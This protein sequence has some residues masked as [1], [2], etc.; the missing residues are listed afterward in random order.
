MQRNKLMCFLKYTLTGTVFLCTLLPMIKAQAT[1]EV[2]TLEKFLSVVKQNHPVAR[3]T[4]LFMDMASAG[5]VEAG[6]AFDP[7]FSLTS[8]QKTFDGKKYYTQNNA[9]LTIPTWYGVSLYGGVQN[10]LGTFLDAEKSP[11]LYT[12]AGVNVSVLKNLILDK[13]RASLQQAKLMQAQTRFENANT[14]NDLI[15]QANLSYFN[16]LKDFLVLQLI[17]QAVQINID[18]F[19]FVKASFL[20]GDKAGIDTIEAKTQLLTFLQQREE[21]FLAY[22]ASRLEL[23]TYLWTENEAPL[24][25][26][27]DVIPDTT[28]IDMVLNEINESDKDDWVRARLDEHPKLA[29][30]DLKLQNL[31]IERKLKFQ[32]FLPKLDLKYDFMRKGDQFPIENIGASFFEDNYKFG[33]SFSMPIFNRSAMGQYQA[34]KAKIQITS[35]D[36]YYTRLQIE[37]KIRFQLIEVENVKNQVNIYAEASE[38]YRQLYEAE[39]FKFSIGESSLFLLNSRNNKFIEAN[40]KWIELRAKLL[41]SKAKLWWSAALP[42]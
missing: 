23:E 35:L 42:N 38:L 20:Q 30:Y 6:G 29:V 19:E 40:Q 17:E 10:N 37:N 14:V 24:Y 26:A 13:R 15:L 7:I 2:L 22:N 18:R 27:S 39:S 9:D 4:N 31:E 8:D 28:T 25:L 36:N 41:A 3:Q 21:Y 5:R 12:Y 32:N 1:F 33:L 11:G 34:T 16:W